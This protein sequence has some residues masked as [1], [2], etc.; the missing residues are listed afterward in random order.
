MIQG[1]ATY[2]GVGSAMLVMTLFVT[3][4]TYADDPGK[5]ATS[6]APVDIREDFASAA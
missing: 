6:C 2:L 4:V 5:G 1:I 3:G